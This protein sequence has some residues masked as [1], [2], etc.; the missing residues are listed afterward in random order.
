M[1][2]SSSYF[3]LSVRWKRF[4][5]PEHKHP[6]KH[7][8]TVSFMKSRD[9]W[10][11]FISHR[12]STL[13]QRYQS[14]SCIDPRACR[15]SPSRPS[16][17]G[18][19]DK[20]TRYL[21]AHVSRLQILYKCVIYCE[22]PTGSVHTEKSLCCDWM[23]LT[24][25]KILTVHPPS[26]SMSQ[27]TYTQTNKC[28]KYLIQYIQ[29]CYNQ[30]YDCCWCYLCLSELVTVFLSELRPREDEVYLDSRRGSDGVDGVHATGL[31]V[32]MVID[33]IA[34]QRQDKRQAAG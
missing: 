26:E 4:S 13:Q 32:V 33:V 34:V 1:L 2:T 12:A 11:G 31:A 17:S 16:S 8:G 5:R 25:V 7:V 6:H 14:P 22:G 28:C 3:F 9:W 29:T 21:T 24:S 10:F 30:N 27:Y 20:H 18:T 19:P 23:T 15:S